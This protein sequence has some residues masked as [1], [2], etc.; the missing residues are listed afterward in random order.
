MSMKLMRILSKNVSSAVGYL[1]FYANNIAVFGKRKLR[2]VAGG[3]DLGRVRVS[4]DELHRVCEN[5]CM[6]RLGKPQFRVE[7]D[8][9]TMCLEAV[10]MISVE[11]VSASLE[12]RM[13]RFAVIMS[14]HLIVKTVFHIFL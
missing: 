2:I 9:V 12:K 7:N 11:G 10:S 3:V 6:R 5:V 4:S 1:D 14:Y 13:K 8:Y